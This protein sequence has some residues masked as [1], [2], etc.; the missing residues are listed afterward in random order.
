MSKTIKFATIAATLLMVALA[1]CKKEQEQKTSVDPAP[2]AT[3]PST[4]EPATQPASQ[5]PKEMHPELGKMLNFSD[6]E[7]AEFQKAWDAAEKI[8]FDKLTSKQQNILGKY[9]YDEDFGSENRSYWEVFG[10]KFFSHAQDDLYAL[11]YYGGKNQVEITASSYLES[12]YKTINYLPENIHD[13][14]YKTAWVPGVKGAKGYGIGEYI[15]YHFNQ[16]TPEITKVIIANGYVKSEKAYRDNSRPKKLKMY[17]DNKLV[18]ILNLQDIRREQ[19]FKFEPIG[20]E[21]GLKKWNEYGKFYFGDK[22]RK[23]KIFEEM[24]ELNKL[25]RWTMK[26]EILEVYKGNKYDDTPIT[27]IYFDNYFSGIGLCLGA[28]TKILMADNSLK[29]IELIKAG[30]MIKSYDFENKK[31]IDTEVAKLLSAQHSN[32]KKLKFTDNEI[33]TTTDHP[34]W[35]DKNAWAAIDAEKA[36]NNYVQKTKVA[37]L[38]KGDKIFVPEK[39]AFSKI[40]D[41]ENISGSQMT[42]TIDLSKSDNFIANG[43]LVKTEVVK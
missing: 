2:A 1:G 43:L 37:D 27:Q 18:A 16:A 24:N 21:E 20:S 5:T 10:L 3:Q 17:I 22:D 40:L 30:D 7:A 9:G 42:Y 32:L 14:S 28:G 29:N 26:F 38:K 25:P 6:E 33:I 31:L 23:E 36:N 19:I 8:G 4:P 13:G 41:I 34:F 35:T 39:N 12:N 11:Y 15:T